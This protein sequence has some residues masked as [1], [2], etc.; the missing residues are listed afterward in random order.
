VSFVVLV[1]ERGRGVTQC[2]EMKT[3]GGGAVWGGG[4]GGGVL[5][6]AAL[7]CGGEL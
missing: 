2:M 4:G 7:L 6:G 5:H 3:D 1:R